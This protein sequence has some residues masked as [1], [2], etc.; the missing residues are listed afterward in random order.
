MRRFLTRLPHLLHF[1]ETAPAASYGPLYFSL[2][3]LQWG[4]RLFAGTIFLRSL[5]F[6]RD[7]PSRPD[8]LLRLGFLSSLMFC[9][10]FW[11][12]PVQRTHFTGRA[13]QAVFVRQNAHA[14]VDIRQH[15][16]II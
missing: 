15:T 1:H 10:L 9:S 13:P 14:I 6:P 16:R 7:L 4:H 12:C 8:G 3:T 2:P 5:G 11:A